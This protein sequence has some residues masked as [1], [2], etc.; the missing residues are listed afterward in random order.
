MAET[1]YGHKE[2]LRDAHP[3]VRALFAWHAIEEMEHRDVAFDVMKQVGNVPESTRKFV[4][5]STTAL[6]FGFTLY[7]A[8][9]MLKH[10]GFSPLQRLQMNIRGLPSFFGRKGTL[11]QN[12]QAISQLV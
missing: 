1:F 7:R 2:P 6:M 10:D 4:L 8:N 3:Y 5:A 12:E 11:T 9:V